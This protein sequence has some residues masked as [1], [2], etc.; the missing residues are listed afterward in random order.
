MVF[1]PSSTSYKALEIYQ[2]PCIH[3]RLDNSLSR[4]SPSGVEE[5]FRLNLNPTRTTPKSTQSSRF[6]EQPVPNNS[7]SFQHRSPSPS[8]GSLV[9]RDK[10]SEKSPENLN[11]ENILA[12]LEDVANDHP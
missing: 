6:V 12:G 3:H 9:N 10:I 8:S 11:S 1:D 2:S 5:S 4:Y 7:G